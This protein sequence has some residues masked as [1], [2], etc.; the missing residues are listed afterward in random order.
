MV[1][2]AGI[3]VALLVPLAVV[4]V[5]AA[6]ARPPETWAPRPGAAGWSVGGAIAAGARL[7]SRALHEGTAALP[8]AK[9]RESTSI[10]GQDT[11]EAIAAGIHF[12]LLGLA[13][14]WIR[15]AKKEMGEKLFVVATGG[16][17]RSVY[18]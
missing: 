11:Q 4:A 13:E 5:A 15:Q 1:R 2:V 10:L 3:A 14:E 7:V 17:G 12:A 6:N 18:Y 16:A 9:T 8:Q